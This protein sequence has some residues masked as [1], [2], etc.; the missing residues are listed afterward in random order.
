LIKQDALR[1]QSTVALIVV[2][3]VAGG[4]FLWSSAQFGLAVEDD[5]VTYLEGA[6]SLAL[7]G[8]YERAGQPIALWPPLYSL[9]IAPA[10][11]LDS[12]ALEYTRH[13]HLVLYIGF[14][15]VWYW[16]ILSTFHCHALAVLAT[17]TLVFSI[18]VAAQALTV[19]SEAGFLF[20]Y[21]VTL[22]FLLVYLRTNRLSWFM[23]VTALSAALPLMR[24]PGIYLVAAIALGLVFSGQ[25]SL[26]ERFRRG[27]AYAAIS[28]IPTA[29]WL[30]HNLV[31]TSTLT[32]EREFHLENLQRTNEQ[33]FATVGSWF[34]PFRFHG[35]H[36]YWFGLAVTATALCALALSAFKARRSDREFLLIC[37][38]S[39]VVYLVAMWVSLTAVVD[40]SRQLLPLYPLLVLGL[41]SAAILV[42]RSI[43]NVVSLKRGMPR[44]VISLTVFAG[45]FL[46]LSIPVVR[47]LDNFGEHRAEGQG[48]TSRRW[49]QSDM[50]AYVRIAPLGDRDLI[51]CDN[52]DL[53]WF[54]ARLECDGRL[55]DRES[56]WAGITRSDGLP[57]FRSK[58]EQNGEPAYLL[59]FKWG[60]GTLYS[61]DE[62]VEL[63]P[64]R[65]VKEFDHGTILLWRP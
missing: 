18:N 53:A 63:L 38:L 64:A 51:F 6:K 23:A 5:S 27:A 8:K 1:V 52:P 57:A 14:G 19:L 4:L 40:T 10:W 16:L 42:M 17:A 11:L 47:G 9:S 39:A 46:S 37:I 29:L 26:T 58:L 43:D 59:D 31:L 15:L 21:S 2:C 25:G 56:V 32:G 36:L 60:R 28:A 65:V 7:I 44:Q 22:A 55:P 30:I 61:S 54:L 62:L 48:M 24:Y 12:D 50:A 49:H 34:L 35:D 33:M 20:L 45:F 13:L 41:S 3:L